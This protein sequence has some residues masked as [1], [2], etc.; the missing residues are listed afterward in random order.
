MERVETC[1][2]VVGTVDGGTVVGVEAC[3]TMDETVCREL[4]A[5]CCEI[6]A[7]IASDCC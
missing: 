6:W 1:W 2:T 3:G 7:S 5:I 4:D